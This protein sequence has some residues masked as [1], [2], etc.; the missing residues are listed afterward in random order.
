MAIAAEVKNAIAVALA[1]GEQVLE[2]FDKSKEITVVNQTELVAALSK[3]YKLTIPQGR[4]WLNGIAA[5]PGD[6]VFH[7]VQGLTRAAQDFVGDS[8]RNMEEVAGLIVAP[9]LTAEIDDIAKLWDK[10]GL[11]G[12]RLTE[13][14]VKTYVTAGK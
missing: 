2:L 13:D 9:S 3:E 1:E 10:F 12:E 6:T 11:M 5:E 8:R 7:M 14:Q 4:A